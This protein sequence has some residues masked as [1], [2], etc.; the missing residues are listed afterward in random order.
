[1]NGFKDD[2]YLYHANNSDKQTKKSVLNYHLFA[3]IYNCITTINNGG[4]YIKTTCQFPVVNTRKVQQ[5]RQ[6]DIYF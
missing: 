3:L 1:M 5:E 2:I 6:I 4:L